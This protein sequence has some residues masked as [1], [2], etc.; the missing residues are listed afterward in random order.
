MKYLN[1]SE[2]ES[3]IHN[4]RVGRS[5]LVD[6]LN[7]DQLIDEIFELNL[8]VCKLKIKLSESDIF[9]KIESIGFPSDILSILIRKTISVEDYDISTKPL[10][11]VKIYNGRNV[12]D[13][14]LHLNDI[15]SNQTALR[16]EGSLYSSLFKS[17]DTQKFIVELFKSYNQINDKNKF[18]LVAY[19]N[20][21]LIGMGIIKVENEEGFGIEV[22][23]VPKHRGNF[24]F[25][26]VM[27]VLMHTIK[28]SDKT[29]VLN[30][31]KTFSLFTILQNPRSFNTY[32][33][34]GYKI[35]DSVL[36]INIFS[37]LNLGKANSK[38]LMSTESDLLT[39]I[40]KLIKS[41]FSLSNESLILTDFKYTNP[42]TETKILDWTLKMSYENENFKWFSF[43][44]SNRKK[45]GYLKYK[46]K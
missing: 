44:E 34:L 32:L 25:K 40:D 46:K 10:L 24:Y 30:K 18:C 31:C 14:D 11:D 8:D 36:N 22:G 33:K 37:M 26:E 1:Y 41:E 3:E 7:V 43:Y 15:V 23:I 20:N 16:F 5:I 6:N 42:N 19:H 38:R 29:S 35:T 39:E 21:E 28:H 13:I 27:N 2:L 45:Y 4:L 9:E 12:D 17:D